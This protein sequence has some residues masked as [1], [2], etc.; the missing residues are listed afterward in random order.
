[1]SLVPQLSV[2]SPYAGSETLPH[3]LASLARQSLDPELF[4]LL[5]VEDGDHGGARALESCGA[6]FAA[7][8]IPLNRPPGFDGH[9]AGLC[10]NVGAR[11]ARPRLR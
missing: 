10:R 6:R 5:L 7:R 9:S 11:R 2:V 8:V 1:M 4:E 3:F